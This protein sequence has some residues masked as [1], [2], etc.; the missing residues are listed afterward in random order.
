M[1]ARARRQKPSRPGRRRRIRSGHGNSYKCHG[2]PH[3]DGARPIVGAWPFCAICRRP[4]SWSHRIG[5]IIQVLT[6]QIKPP[7]SVPDT[8]SKL[9]TCALFLQSA[10]L[11]RTPPV[12]PL[13]NTGKRV[14]ATSVRKKS[15]SHFGQ[16]PSNG[17]VS[18][19]YPE[20]VTPEMK[21]SQ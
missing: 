4:M 19:R 3:Q 1:C 12:V 11:R 13:R 8:C 7:H 15:A 14:P 5:A 6:G 21:T 16:Q 10:A 17:Q 18:N 20:Y 9:A 2:W